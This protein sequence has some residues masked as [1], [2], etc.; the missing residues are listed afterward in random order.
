MAIQKTFTDRSGVEHK[1]A[2]FKVVGIMIHREGVERIEIS[3]A[4]YPN[5]A[6]SDS[7]KQP[8]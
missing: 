6:A 7:L 8:L 4:S 2:Y 1:D 3:L 5:K